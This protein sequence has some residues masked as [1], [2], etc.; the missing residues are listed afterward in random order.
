[1]LSLGK[2]SDVSEGLASATLA[3]SD[4][5]LAAHEFPLLLL[6]EHQ[7][8]GVLEPDLDVLIGL[9]GA[10][11]EPLLEEL[12][13]HVLVPVSVGLSDPVLHHEGRLH[14]LRSL[15]LGASRVAGDSAVDCLVVEL[16]VDASL[17]SIN[18]ILLGV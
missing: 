15:A 6:G 13:V 12:L 9:L 17:S 8:H 18:I 14:D 3:S 10:L 1:M 2:V 7:V 4:G 11:A 16:D 5:F